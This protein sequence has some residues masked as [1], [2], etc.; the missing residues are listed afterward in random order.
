MTAESLLSELEAAR[1]LLLS[2]RTL[3]KLRAEG[4]IRYVALTGRRVA[5]RPQDLE[6]FVSARV[7]EGKPCQQP[8]SPKPKQRR[9]GNIIPF[10][11]RA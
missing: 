7:K 3:R 6:A 10:S 9:Q 1:R 8:P 2:E 11:Q 4:Q 5:Y